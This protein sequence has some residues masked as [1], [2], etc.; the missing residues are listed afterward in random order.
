LRIHRHG[1]QEK[2]AIESEMQWMAHLAE[3]GLQVPAP[4]AN[5]QN[6]LVAE[7]EAGGH[8]HLADVLTWLDGTPLGNSSD[9]LNFSAGA[10][11]CIFF[12]LGAGMAKLHAISDAWVLPKDFKRHSWDRDGFVGES[13]F[14]G[15]FWEASELN[16]HDR[17]TLLRA[18]GKAAV[19]LDAL[20]DA[21]ADFGLIH[22]DFVRQNVL[23]TGASTRL[24]D[25]DDSGFGFRMYDFATALWKNR[26]EPHYGTIKQSLFAGY[27]SC[28]SLSRL[29]ERSLD[30]FLALRDFAF[31]GWMDAR[32]AEPGVEARMPTVRATTLAAAQIFLRA[33]PAI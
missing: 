21:G 12:D 18:R 33:P 32:R 15:A 13:P 30:L 28:R 6:K 10:L 3:N 8:V 1:Y 9:P 17:S 27:R 31:L 11:Q 24:I 29:D 7:I 5:S 25:F 4:I 16:E 26:A 23:V 20:K 22:A 2:R 19:E 14:W